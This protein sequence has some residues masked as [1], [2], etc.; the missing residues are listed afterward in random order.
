MDPVSPTDQQPTVP[1]SQP[2]EPVPTVPPTTPETTPNIPA[3]S[4][5]GLSSKQKLSLGIVAALFVAAVPLS[6]MVTRQTRLDSSANTPL[7]PITPITPP[8]VTAT[9]TSIYSPTPTPTSSQ[10]TIKLDTVPNENHNFTFSTSGDLGD[11]QFILDDP[12]KNDGDKHKDSK[13]FTVGP[14]A[15]VGIYL[16][17]PSS[18]PGANWNIENIT[19]DNT[20][21]VIEAWD[22]TNIYQGFM[23]VKLSPGS[24]S[25]C[26]YTVHRNSAINTTIYR[27]DN[28][29]G[30]KN[31]GDPGLKGW[32]VT[33]YDPEGSAITTPKSGGN[34]EARSTQ[35]LPFLGTYTVCLYLQPG[36]ANSDPGTI[37]PTRNMPCKQI[38]ITAPGTT[39]KLEFGNYKVT[40]T[41]TATPTRRPTPTSN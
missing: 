25:L 30:K 16:E 38:N 8:P 33:I 20:V 27:D 11:T 17:L 3:A 12:G 28:R 35:I 7:T 29:N 26:T 24:N 2:A 37:D 15:T 13:T 1:P 14:T 31:S 34:G 32:E 9:P 19:C 22:P 5:S 39:N 41:P 18:S 23:S 4:Q 21:Q 36:W 6:Y 10:I 40:P